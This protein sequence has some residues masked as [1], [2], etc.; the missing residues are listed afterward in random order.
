[1]KHPTLL[2]GVAVALATSIAGSL[3]FSLIPLP[4]FNPPVLRLLISVTG[5]I[6]SI[7]LLARSTE[8][9]GRITAAV[10]W[11]MLGVACWILNFPL[12]LYLL[13]H[14]AAVWVIRS[15]YFHSGLLSALADLGLIG[16]GL[17]AAAWA[18][19]HTGSLF[20][21]IWCFFL[22]QALFVFIPRPMPG[23]TMRPAGR[24]EDKFE[25][26][27]SNAQAALHRLCTSY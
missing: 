12:S 1:M 10:A 24:S 15:L 25:R 17:S 4:L 26:A 27:Y 13:I 6:Y 2:E 9:V 16:L 22:A 8:P 7:Y 19:K 21:A 11:I 5:F 3:L 20:L 14:L 18:L 23:G